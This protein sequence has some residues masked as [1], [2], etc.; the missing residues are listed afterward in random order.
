MRIP[1]KTPSGARIVGIRVL[2]DGTLKLPV[3]LCTLTGQ[4]KH[5]RSGQTDIIWETLR[6]AS[7]D[8]QTPSYV[9]VDEHEDLWSEA[10]LLRSFTP[11]QGDPDAQDPENRAA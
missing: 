7:W 4:V 5:G 3:E 6:E 11:F 2:L 1:L 10:D 9:Y 8:F